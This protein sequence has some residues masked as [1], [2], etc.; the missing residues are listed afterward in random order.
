MQLVKLQWNHLMEQTKFILYGAGGH[1]KVVLSIIE[2][3]KGVLVGVID[4]DSN[5]KQ[6]GGISVLNAYD[7]NIFPEARLIISI[8]DNQTRKKLVEN[9]SHQSEAIIH[10]SSVIDKQVTIGN[11]T[12]VMQNV[13]I[14]RA[15][16]IGNH[17]IINT[18]STIDHE[19]T[20][21]DFAHIG[22][23]VVLCGSVQVGEGTLIG[24][25]STV[26]PGVKIGKWSTIGAGSIVLFDVQDNEMVVG[27]PARKIIK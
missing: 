5:K 15:V 23:G 14:Q 17:V 6:F 8:G 12:V 27:N 21:S 26:L 20:I 11:G 3:N 1:S 25:G 24:A 16:S 7:P 13:T 4:S 22:P 19:T 2:D 9:I 10:S 18:S